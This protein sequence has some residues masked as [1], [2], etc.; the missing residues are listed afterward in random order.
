MMPPADAIEM[1][2]D[3]KQRGYLADP[4]AVEYERGVL[5]QKYGYDLVMRKPPI[6]KDPLQIFLG[7]HP[8]WVV[9]LKDKTILKP[10]DP[11]IIKYYS[12]S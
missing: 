7:L 1:Y 8:G 4:Q 9:N 3:P 5:A 10:K 12:N 11:E 6:R 2:T